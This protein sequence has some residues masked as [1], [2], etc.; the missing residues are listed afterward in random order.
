VP[1]LIL[2]LGC[3]V[4]IWLIS[5]PVLASSCAAIAFESKIDQAQ[6]VMVVRIVRVEDATSISGRSIWSS[7]T[8]MAA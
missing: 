6:T 4:A 2:R 3:A 1:T 7:P 8:P 5:L